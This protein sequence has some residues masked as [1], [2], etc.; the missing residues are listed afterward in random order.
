MVTTEATPREQTADVNGVHVRVGPWRDG[1][2][3]AS[4][5]P[6]AGGRGPSWVSDDPEAVALARAVIAEQ[7]GEEVLADYLDDN[8]QPDTCGERAASLLRQHVTPPRVHTRTWPGSGTATVTDMANAGKRGKTCRVLRFNGWGAGAARPGTPEDRCG[9][10]CQ[11]VCHWLDGIS[12]HTDFEALRAELLA[13][14]A[15]YT[16][17]DPEAA[18]VYG[19]VVR[20]EQIRGVD[21]PA[22]PLTAG[23]PGAWSAGADETGVT[24][25]DLDDVNEWM[26]ITPSRQSGSEAYRRAAKVWARVR[27]AKT[28]LEASAILRAAGCKLH[29]YCGRD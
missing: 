5:Y 7:R 3:A 20:D 13:R 2:L 28:R 23:V 22:V 29:G 15:A 9:G 4:V 8:P 1:G 11:G 17:G 12:L 19:I 16:A 27:T 10:F 24:I 21:A 6:L 14:L 26:E 25:R 18:R